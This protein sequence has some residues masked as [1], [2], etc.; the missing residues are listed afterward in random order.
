MK[1]GETWFRRPGNYPVHWK[2]WCLVGL[3]LPLTGAA[4]A[5]VIA[6]PWSWLRLVGVALLAAILVGFNAVAYSRSHYRD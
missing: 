5:L 1:R 6:A 3:L 4:L 2:G